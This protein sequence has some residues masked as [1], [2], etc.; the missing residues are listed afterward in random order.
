MLLASSYV[1]SAQTP[2]S[3]PT[4]SPWVA[5]T[6]LAPRRMR[7]VVSLSPPTLLESRKREAGKAAPPPRK[8]VFVCPE[9][10]C[11][12]HHPPCAL[13]SA[14]AVKLHLHR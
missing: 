9:P 7:E 10:S 8:R 14:S 2:S 1:A 11:P 6:D 12:H 4:T 13:S 3:L 5:W